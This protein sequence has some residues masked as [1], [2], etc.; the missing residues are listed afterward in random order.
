MGLCE[1][2]GCHRC[3]TVQQ[4]AGCT[5]SS[6]QALCVADGARAAGAQGCPAYIRRL[7]RYDRLCSDEQ[8]A[9]PPAGP[10]L[11]PEP[12]PELEPEL[13]LEPAP[14][15]IIH[16]SDGPAMVSE[17]TDSKRLV[18]GSSRW[19]LPP[20]ARQLQAVL[21]AE[22]G[23]TL[24][25]LAA[26][27]GRDI[28]D[29]IFAKIEEADTFLVFGTR[30]YG[31]N[32]GNPASTYYEAKFA[33][34]AQKRILLIQMMPWDEKFDHLTARVLFGMNRLTLDWQLGAPM[35]PDLPAMIVRALQLEDTPPAS[36]L[37]PAAPA[38]A[39]ADLAEPQPEDESDILSRT[40]P[41]EQSAETSVAA[42]AHTAASPV[43]DAAALSEGSP[44]EPF[45]F[46]REGLPNGWDVIENASRMTSAEMS[47]SFSRIKAAIQQNEELV[48][49]LT[50][51]Q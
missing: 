36:A 38:T 51:R 12:E 31:E 35:P 47:G 15:T 44:V 8:P 41:T 17:C 45:G 49:H 20:E 37:A 19:P 32:T 9:P 4:I 6:R 13:E 30:N 10:E 43:S 3:E 27:P 5:W 50:S 40:S 25:L 22:H 46:S 33:Q 14:S 39:A 23:V 2:A 26:E 42:A 1:G 34:N 11:E 28:S 48:A 24:F 18:F 7:T 16:T 21:D 29:E